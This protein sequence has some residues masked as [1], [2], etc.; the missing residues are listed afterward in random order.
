[1][2]IEVM[3]REGREGEGEGGRKGSEKWGGKTKVYKRWGRKM[4]SEEN[5]ESG[6]P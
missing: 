3:G 4:G 1:M 5:Y 2:G 6:R